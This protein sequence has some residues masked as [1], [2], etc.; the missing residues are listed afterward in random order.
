MDDLDKARELAGSLV[1]VANGAGMKTTALLTDMNQPLARAS[2]NAVEVHSAIDFLTG[3]E[4]DSRLWDVTIALGSDMLVSGGLARDSDDGH[5]KMEQAFS[6][7]RAAETFARMV[8]ELGGPDD[9]MERP[10]KHLPAAPVVKPVLPATEGSVT[11]VD[12]RGVGVSVVAMGGGRVR[13]ADCVDPAVG[14]TQLATIGDHVDGETPLG[15][16]H[17]RDEAQAERAAK[18]LI[19]AYTLGGAREVPDAPVVIE[20]IDAP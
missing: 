4:V 10:E 13:A 17:A 8:V 2:G 5:R 6:S 1:N 11:A 14:F 12:T 9:L 15:F 18:E 7:G 20:R 16:V 19:A 3:R